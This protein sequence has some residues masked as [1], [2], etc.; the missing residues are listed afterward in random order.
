[1]FF[2]ILTIFEPI[3]L[4]GVKYYEVIMKQNL[5]FK[6]TPISTQSEDLIQRQTFSKEAFR[7]LLETLEQP[8]SIIE[9]GSDYFLGKQATENEKVI[10]SAPAFVPTQFGDASFTQTYGCQFPLYAGAMAGGISS[11]AM[12]IAMGKAGFMGSFGAGGM[13]PDRLESAILEIKAALPNG[14]Y[15]F[16]LLNSPFE[17]AME[18]NTVTLYLKHGVK[19]IE[20]SAYLTITPNLVWYRASGLSKNT[21]GSVQIGNKIIA[22]VSR[23]EVASRFLQPAPAEILNKLVNA[24]KI[25]AEQAE[26]AQ[27]VPMAD[28]ITAEADSGGH[29][30]NRPLVCIL[31]AIIALRNAYQAQYQFSQP[32]RIG[33][34]GGI[35]TPESAFAAFKMGA[36]YVVTGSVNQACVEAGASEHTRKLLAQM[37]LTDVAMAPASDMFEMGTKVQVL[38]RGTMFA[39]RGQ[40]LFDIYSRY[41]SIEEI[42]QDE[43]E[44][45][46]KTTFKMTLNE[47]WEECL[48]F[49]RQRDPSQIERAEKDPK[50][51]MALIFRWYL[52]L[53]SRWSSIGTQ[54][55]EMDYQI[56][57]GPSMGAFN[58]WVKGTYLE[59]YTQRHCADISSHI[60]KGAAVL[61]RLDVLEA[62]GL[63][64][65]DELR[66][67]KPSKAL[68]TL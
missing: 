42:P 20:A 54:G 9:K 36:A 1:M 66:L 27:K 64:F 58:D 5:W 35:S 24:G 25:S 57:T 13:L 31:P 55:R 40:K 62:H 38:K 67:Y 2:H 30:D 41:N 29:T 11:T 48:K 33:A 23:K 10:A 17:P 44:K 12:V 50:V 15:L 49:F 43:R 4:Y 8:F 45:L 53:A 61:Q 46:E 56:W 21:D 19:A 26:L 16:N 39:M 47:V 68:V 37:D 22:K 65:E 60:L 34:G 59:D 28:D 6:H 14:N 7:A 63:R 51:K 52:G 32:V 18:E 3:P